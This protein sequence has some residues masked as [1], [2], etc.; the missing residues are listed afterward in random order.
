MFE[1]SNAKQNQLQAIGSIHQKLIVQRDAGS[2]MASPKPSRST[3]TTS[4]TATTKKRAR[5]ASVDLS[6]T[7]ALRKQS[8]SPLISKPTI[9]SPGRLSATNRL[10]PTPRSVPDPLRLS[11]T[12]KRTAKPQRP[13]PTSANTDLSIKDQVIHLLAISPL[14]AMSISKR[15]GHATKSLMP[16]L[17]V[18][19]RYEIPGKYHLKEEYLQVVSLDKW[20]YTDEERQRVA[21]TL[22]GA[23]LPVPTSSSGNAATPEVTDGP[24][25]SHDEYLALR[26]RFERDY[27]KYEEVDTRLKQIAEQFADLSRQLDDAA[28]ARERQRLQNDVRRLYAKVKPES[29]ALKADFAAMHAALS[30]IKARIKDY[31]ASI[32]SG[33]S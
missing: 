28:S 30:S 32:V 14:S 18:V 12:S 19:A 24:I 27:V 15:L 22:T 16:I 26:D 5:E 21:E 11:S 7:S 8:Q 4:T 33:K 17:K 3:V 2:T 1:V 20:P 31:V 25:A 9:S 6:S 23:G 10:T 13:S 29:D